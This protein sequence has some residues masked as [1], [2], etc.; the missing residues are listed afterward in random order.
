MKTPLPFRGRWRLVE[1]ELWDQDFLDLVVEA[2]ITIDDDSLGYFQF[3]AVEGQ[4]DCRFDTDGGKP[5]AAF[6]WRGKTMAIRP[7]V[8]AGSPSLRMIASKADSSFT[9]A[10]TLLSLGRV[11]PRR[12]P[13]VS[14]LVGVLDD[15]ESRAVPMVI[16][17]RHRVY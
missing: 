10:M 12:P 9:Q 3:G 16:W 13:S 8:V 4:V 15:S 17:Q 5:R 7:M 6:S 2:H 1:M 11:R 14:L